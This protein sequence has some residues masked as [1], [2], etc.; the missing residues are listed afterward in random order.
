MNT[1]MYLCVYVHMYLYIN[2]Y[3][4]IYITEISKKKTLNLPPTSNYLHN[5]YIVL[6][7]VSNPEMI[8]IVQKNVQRLYANITP[9]YMDIHGFWYPQAMPGTNPHR[10]RGTNVLWVEFCPS[11]MYLLRSQH[12]VLWNVILPGK[13]S[14]Q[15][16]LVR[17]MSY[18]SKLGPKSNMTHV[19]IKR[20]YLDTSAQ[21]RTSCE[22]EDRDQCDAA[23][24]ERAKVASKP[25]SSSGTDVKQ[26]LPYRIHKEPTEP[27]P[28]TPLSQIST[29]KN[30]RQ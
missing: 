29:D 12:T 23:D 13:G 4:Q 19:L 20:E 5:V 15:M 7:V 17:I 6:R 11:K 14:L 25:P 30:V 26:I 8:Q 1:H 27:T 18:C 2:I 21:G 22:D 28:P 9:F 16:Q 10:Y 24:Q 3:K